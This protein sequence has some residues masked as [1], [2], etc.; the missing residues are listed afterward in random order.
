MVDTFATGVVCRLPSPFCM[1]C[2]LSSPDQLHSLLVSLW[3]T[4][5]G[6]HEHLFGWERMQPAAPMIFALCLVTEAFCTG[7]RSSRL[8]FCLGLGIS[9]R[10]LMGEPQA[11]PHLSC[12]LSP[13]ILFPLAACGSMQAPLS[14]PS[15]NRIDVAPPPAPPRLCSLNCAVLY[16]R[17]GERLGWKRL[18]KKLPRS[19]Y[20]SVYILLLLT[21]ITSLTV[22]IAPRLTVRYALRYDY[23][24]KGR[25]R[26]SAS[27][28]TCT[29]FFR[30]ASGLRYFESKAAVNFHHMG[31]LPELWKRA[32]LQQTTSTRLTAVFSAGPGLP[33]RRPRSA[34]FAVYSLA[35]GCK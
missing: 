22:I 28:F 13:H 8:T 14:L 35:P 32:D 24:C 20:A 23:D 5:E 31:R 18:P 12:V 19:G 25:L 7:S 1:W 10:Y 17:T 26:H 34:R 2:Y 4:L 33:I 11:S 27:H 6:V 21:V 16:H 15:D 9:T 29:V 30:Q 3:P